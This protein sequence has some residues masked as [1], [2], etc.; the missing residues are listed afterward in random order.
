MRSF[1]PWAPLL[2]GLF[3]FGC[4]QADDTS[5]DA[6]SNDTGLSSR[7]FCEAKRQIMIDRS[8]ECDR[9]PGVVVERR[10]EL[11][12][13]CT[14]LPATVRFDPASAAECLEALKALPCHRFSAANLAFEPSGSPE[15]CRKAVSGT[16]EAGA[17]CRESTECADGLCSADFD[18]HP[19]PGVCIPFALEGKACT[20]LTLGPAVFDDCAP[21]LDC[22]AGLCVATA[23][24]MGEGEGCSACG[25]CED[26]LLCLE[27][28]CAA[29]QEGITCQNASDCGEGEPCS[30]DWGFTCEQGKCALELGKG[31]GEACQPGECALPHL[32]CGDGGTCQ[33]S[34]GVGSPCKVQGP[35]AE[36][37]ACLQGRCDQPDPAAMGICVALSAPGESCDSDADCD[38]FASSHCDEDSKTCVAWCRA[39]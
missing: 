26:G 28:K 39:E 37:V 7:E 5:P 9:V 13:A 12:G 24:K 31:V 22:A 38:A 34:N 3:V 21:G 6:G 29:L 4:A 10:F 15:A 14:D 30:Y 11:S 19:C 35:G 25:D 2:A 8:L 16:L 27:G 17:P 23:K 32:F 36:L 20:P 1:K 33:L 18:P